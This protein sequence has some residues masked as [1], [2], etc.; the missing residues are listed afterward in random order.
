VIGI[1]PFRSLLK[2]LL[3]T[4]EQRDIVLLYANKMENEIVYRDVLDAVQTKLGVGVFCTLADTAN[5]RHNW[6]GLIGRI[7]EYRTCRQIKQFVVQYQ[8]HLERKV[9]RSW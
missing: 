9:C 2:Y 4:Q 5:I 3:D 6:P 8:Y 1:T 7:H